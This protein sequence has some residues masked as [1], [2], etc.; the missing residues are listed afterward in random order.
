MSGEYS[1]AG[2]YT[3]VSRDAEDGRSRRRARS[4]SAPRRSR[5]KA[6]PTSGSP[7]RWSPGTPRHGR[8]SAARRRR[9]RRRPDLRGPGG[10]AGPDPEADDP[11][12]RHRRG[13]SRQVRGIG[14]VLPRPGRPASRGRR[15]AAGRPADVRGPPDT[16][17][18]STLARE[19]DRRGPAAPHR[20]AAGVADPRRV[21]R[22]ARGRSSR[23]TSGRRS[24]TTATRSATRSCRHA[25]PTTSRA[26][27]GAG[28]RRGL[29]D[30]RSASTRP[31]A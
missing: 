14:D 8:R 3:E 24:R 1:V 19:A 30:A 15:R 4:P 23:A 22:P 12:R 29:R 21:A 13:M 18:S 7:A 27:A 20:G 2:S 16:S 11:R 25:R 26:S 31:L 9:V 6:S 10:A 5:L 17:S 28:R